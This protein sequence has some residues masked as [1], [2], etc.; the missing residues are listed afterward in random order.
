MLMV[1]LLSF[2]VVNT[3][4]QAAPAYLVEETAIL[5]P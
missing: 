3:A 5:V 2:Y 1:V 4:E